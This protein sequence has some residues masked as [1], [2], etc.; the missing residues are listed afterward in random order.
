MRVRRRL[1][2]GVAL[3]L[4]TAACGDSAAPPPSTG[5]A[6]PPA[7]VS[8]VPAGW[9][10]LPPGPLSPR[11]NAHALW[12]GGELL[13]MGGSDAP[14]CPAGAD[15][16]TTDVPAL[17]DGA[18]LDLATG[19]WRPIAPAPVPLW[20]GSGVVLD[21]V[22]YL[23]LDGLDRRPGT[24]QAFLAY[25]PG[26][27]RWERL[28]A[29]DPPPGFARL[30][31]AGRRLA[32]YQP[33]QEHG[34]TGDLLFDT[35]TATWASLPADP[36]QPAYDRAV[37]W[38]G[39]ELVLLGI[40]V[41]AVDDGGP[42][43]YSAAGYDPEADAWRRL[44]DSGIA[45]SDPAWYW[46]AGRVVNPTSGGSDGGAVNNFGRWYPFGGMLDPG[47]ATWLP[48]LPQPPGD[49]GE[50]TG[51]AAGGGDL[52]LDSRGW[53]LDAAD[54]DWIALPA[55]PGGVPS[56]AAVAWAGDDL[57]MWGGVAW[58]GSTAWELL[59]TGWAWAPGG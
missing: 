19:A 39:T 15:C 22:V 27:D 43:V 2:A 41:E 53:V 3:A 21:G 35:A 5:A 32:L 7:S 40:P 4:L 17:R 11:E 49:F 34:V 16:A 9:R 14:P 6:A 12:V 52:L 47:S 57:V 37:V 45:G 59:A 13:V 58:T 8:E 30:A 10:E 23:W 48:A 55:P 18:A 33:S 42:N 1:L 28:P 31:A 38:T 44:P 36:L 25:H 24:E 56:G 50:F 29:P 26:E 46:A 51:Y 54:L 20:H